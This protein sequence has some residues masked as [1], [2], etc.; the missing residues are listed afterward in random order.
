[1]ID[2]IIIQI[3]NY[4][5]V[6]GKYADTLVINDTLFTKYLL[7]AAKYTNVE[8]DEDSDDF[9]MYGLKVIRTHDIKGFKV[10]K[11]DI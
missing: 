5:R 4:M 9:T 7:E 10:A 1:M 6:T 11:L 2:E 8:I 3:E